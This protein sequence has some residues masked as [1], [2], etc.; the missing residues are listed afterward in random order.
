MSVTMRT[1][2]MTMDLPLQQG[3]TRAQY[4]TCIEHIQLNKNKSLG[5]F[6]VQERENWQ[7]IIKCCADENRSPLACQRFGYFN[8]TT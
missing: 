3:P 6:T 5:L 4:I 7:I 1:A 8:E 2:L